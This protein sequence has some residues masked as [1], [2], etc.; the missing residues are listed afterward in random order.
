MIKSVLSVKLSGVQIGIK[1]NFKENIDEICKSARNQLNATERLK[2][3]LE[4]KD[5]KALID[6]SF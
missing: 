6:R 3:F 5:V 4:P 1:L 2:S